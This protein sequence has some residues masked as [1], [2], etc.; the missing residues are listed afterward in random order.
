MDALFDLSSFIIQAVNFIIVALVLRKFFFVPYIKFLDEE[1][2]K[3]KDLEEKLA[4]S[5]ALLSEAKNDAEKILDQS[6]VDAR[7]VASEIVENS[8]KEAREIEE[9]AQRDADVARTK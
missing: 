5:D 4:K 3:R 9:R 1:A 7:M 6:R 2:M 8:R